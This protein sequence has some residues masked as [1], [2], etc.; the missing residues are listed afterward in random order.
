MSVIT[1]YEI[2]ELKA[3][4]LEWSSEI[5]KWNIEWRTG[6]YPGEMA[7]F[8]GLCDHRGIKSIVESGRGEDAYSTQILGEYSKKN[9]T[10]II[11][12]D[13]APTR[14]KPFQKKLEQ[15]SN[16][17][18]ISGDAF[19]ALPR[20]IE[21]LQRPTALLVDGP[22]LHVAN[23]LSTVTNVMFDIG[24]I[25]HHNCPLS[26]PWGEE[27]A[28]L[29]PGAF[30]YEDLNLSAVPEWQEFKHW[31]AAWVRGYEQFDKKHG[32]IGRSLQTSSLALATLP[33]DGRSVGRLFKAESLGA[34]YRALYL[35]STW[36]FRK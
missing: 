29:F 13:F 20:A 35:W 22:K 32:M 24:V 1:E 11:S 2:Q 30:C 7:A 33:L 14:S 8:L 12:I 26:S 17:H 25:A 9:G 34:K 18:C 21:D 3:K 15:Y 28:R 19:K 6:I 36:L 5:Q 27:F 10:S 4:I 31:E 23:T 16:L